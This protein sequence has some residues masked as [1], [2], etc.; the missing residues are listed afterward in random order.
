MSNSIW[1]INQLF[2]FLERIGTL[3]FYCS[4]Q[5]SSKIQHTVAKVLGLANNAVT[6]E[7]CRMGGAFGGKE[8]NGNLPVVTT[9]L[10]CSLTGRTSKVC[11]DR[12]QNITIIGKGMASLSIARLDLM[13]KVKILGGIF[14]QAV[15]CG[16]SSL[17]SN[18]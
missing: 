18:L 9:T 11:Y 7:F 8:S 12:N 15:S 6:V 4:S 2:V 13:R 16:M 1:K 14:E 5:H 10:V 17:G 3:C